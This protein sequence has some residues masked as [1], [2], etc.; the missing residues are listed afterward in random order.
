MRYAPGIYS[1]RE[2]IDLALKSRSPYHMVGWM[3]ALGFGMN[4]LRGRGPSANLNL[5]GID[6]NAL[7]AK[8]NQLVTEFESGSGSSGTWIEDAAQSLQQVR[9][10]VDECENLLPTDGRDANLEAAL[11]EFFADAG[12]S[13]ELWFGF[14]RSSR[15]ELEKNSGRPMRKTADIVQDIESATSYDQ[16]EAIMRAMEGMNVPGIAGEMIR[17]ENDQVRKSLASSRE[18]DKRMQSDQGDFQDI[19]PEG[20]MEM[21]QPLLKRACA[22]CERDRRINAAA[23]QAAYRG[24]MQQLRQQAGDSPVA[25]ASAVPAP[26]PA[27]VAAAPEPDPVPA[28][29]APAPVPVAPVP[30]PAPVA[31]APEP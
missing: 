31:A 25:P 26:A 3:K 15:E 2:D 7:G 12:K 9:Q 11:E 4:A 23:L 18:M 5:G 6:K 1:I 30:A 21:V 28:A 13:Q 10:L 19:V 22:M 8:M 17:Y 20:V 14:S 24:M 27:P 16:M 29:P